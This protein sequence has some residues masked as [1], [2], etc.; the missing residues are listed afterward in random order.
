MPAKSWTS[1][2][3]QVPPI[4]HSIVENFFKKTNDKRH[5]TEGYAFLVTKTP[6]KPLQVNFDIKAE[7][8]AF[9]LEGYTRPAMRQ[10]KGISSGQRLF[11]CTILFNKSGEI[12]A[13]K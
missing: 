3:E 11:K 13:A 10:A 8:G 5:L 4:T 6:G 9:L 12:L 2:I 1:S 7:D